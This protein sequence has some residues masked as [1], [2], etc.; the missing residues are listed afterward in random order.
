ME[1]F[2][3]SL[4]GDAISPE[5][6]L[7]IFV[8]PA[9]RSYRFSNAGD[10]ATFVSALPNTS[11]IY[12]GMGLINPAADGRGKAEDVRCIGG[13]WAD[14]DLAG[15]PHK[16]SLPTELEEVASLFPIPPSWLISSGYGVHAYWAFKEPWIF[17][18]EGDRQ[19]AAKLARE[20]H[21]E[22]C[23][24]GA[25]AGWKLE[26]LGDL[27]RVLRTPGT[28]NNKSIPREVVFAQQDSGR[29]F[30]P[31]DFAGFI[32]P[33]PAPISPPVFKHTGTHKLNDLERCLKYLDTM[34]PAIEGDGG[35]TATFQ[36]CKAIAGFA[37]DGEQARAAFDH[38]NA[39]CVPPWE[40]EKEIA[41]KIAQGKQHGA[42][43]A[44]RDAAGWIP[45]EDWGVDLSFLLDPARERTEEDDDDEFCAAMVPPTGLLR[46]IYDYYTRAIYRQCP[47]FALATSIAV[48]QSL[49]GRKVESETGLRTN[50][51]HMILA[52]TTSGKEGTLTAINALFNAAG[53]E[54]RILPEK[55]QSGNGL[56]AA[57]K[58]TPSCIWVCDEFG[59]VL[60]SILDKKK[61]DINARAI[62]G[63]LL[64]LYGKSNS[65]F[66][67]SA[68][69]GKKDHA[70]NQ[71]HLCVLGV[72]TGYTV[73]QEITQG[74]VMDGMLGRVSFWSVQSR[75]KPN[76][77]LDR[78]IPAELAASIRSWDQF[79]P[80]GNN[81]GEI[82]PS[83]V[84]IP[85]SPEARARWRE[86]EQKIDLRMENERAIRSAL[87]GRAAARSMK[88]ALTYRLARLAGPAE[89]NEF[90]D[91]RIE[92]N[93]IN[94][95]IAVSNWN[96]RLA[97]SLIG[98][99]IADTVGSMAQKKIETF[100]RAA[101]GAVVRKRDI[102]RAF[103]SLDDGQIT[104]AINELSLAGKIDVQTT[105]GK[106][107][108][109]I[110][111]QWKEKSLD[112]SA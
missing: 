57:V 93:D 7:S 59:Y 46:E 8:L 23:R 100:I 73:F 83:V 13:L 98:E 24:R 75:P 94:W 33:K 70:I 40:K 109:S 12:H 60:Q 50:D 54:S 34:A 79:L 95:G 66:T 62:G 1:V 89:L 48:M 78:E 16:N 28:W 17:K 47:V 44:L 63:I 51:Y 112:K 26:N 99:Q 81:L 15:G 108:P 69:A 3:R 77:N 74:Q 49:L 10:A 29:R 96:T 88:L 111:V 86:H 4:F 31:S 18:D 71:P 55:M 27:A 67:G 65:V 32:V 102:R 84:S 38:Y 11:D 56:L 37:L 105:T 90:S 104:A 103:R 19:A 101:G 42:W 14:I 30:L 106:G 64:S 58:E 5:R 43:G 20:W 80:P 9:K 97:C 21:G 35:G 91:V 36:A 87:W 45:E 110:Q 6:Q 107:P 85:F 52:P 92:L 25:E 53:C 2:F 61:G 39:R 22:I 72:S 68:Y 41:Y 76:H 82:N